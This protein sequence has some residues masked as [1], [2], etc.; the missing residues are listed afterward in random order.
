MA[1]RIA[2]YV[3]NSMKLSPGEYIVTGSWVQ[4]KVISGQEN[5]INQYRN[6]MLINSWKITSVMNFTT[7]S[8]SKIGLK[9]SSE[10]KEAS[11]EIG[12]I[13]VDTELKIGFFNA[14]M[15]D[16]Y[17]GRSLVG[18]VEN[19]NVGA[20]IYTSLSGHILAAVSEFNI[21]SLQNDI[22]IRSKDGLFGVEVFGENITVDK[23]NP[24]EIR[25]DSNP[26]ILLNELLNTMNPLRAFIVGVSKEYNNID[27]VRKQLLSEPAVYLKTGS[28]RIILSPNNEGQ[29]SLFDTP[30]SLP[31]L[32][33][34]KV[35]A[36]A[37]TGDVHSVVQMMSSNLINARKHM[38]NLLS[39]IRP[40]YKK[41]TI[42]VSLAGY[43]KLKLEERTFH[44]IKD[45]IKLISTREVEIVGKI[46]AID[47]IRR[48]F[49]IIDVE[50]DIDWK[51]IYSKQFKD[52]FNLRSIENV[53]MSVNASTY[54]TPNAK[55]G[56]AEYIN[57]KIKGAE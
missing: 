3:D 18:Q 35:L 13:V 31:Y 15:S 24:L 54:T 53:M 6:E 39:M 21:G 16:E 34:Y 48:W 55:K 11:L 56:I 8:G 20:V 37:E 4:S 51:I 10:S 40:Y 47:T 1:G 9:L 5:N 19:T 33:L 32:L 38:Y 28:I 22:L 29:L 46:Y 27:K 52:Q 43:K 7:F 14:R 26:N 23:E 17:D 57:H 49:K 50:S 42:E 41:G 12:D 44:T 25:V 36:A 2:G 30:P 45:A